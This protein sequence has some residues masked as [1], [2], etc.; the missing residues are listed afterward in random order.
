M[1]LSVGHRGSLIRP[2]AVVLL[3]CA[4]LAACGS[5]TVQGKGGAVPLAGKGSPLPASW[6][7][8]RPGTIAS[9]LVWTVIGDSAHGNY[10][11]SML[12]SSGTT[13]DTNTLSFA[14]VISGSSVTLNLDGGAGSVSGTVNSGQ[15]QIE[16]PDSDG[17]IQS[18]DLVPGTAAAFNSDVAKIQSIVN[19]NEKVAAK[20]Q[21]AQQ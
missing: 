3:A 12:D 6:V 4:C 1:K 21:A 18:V 7:Y 11:S 10:T 19:S 5:S 13:I 17:T 2:G 16:I 9:L 15:L 20:Q 14:G 8:F